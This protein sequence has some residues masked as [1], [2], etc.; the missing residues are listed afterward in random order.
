[1]AKKS[2]KAL[3]TVV[4]AKEIAAAAMLPLWLGN[5]MNAVK[6]NRLSSNEDLLFEQ[7]A[8]IMITGD[9]TFY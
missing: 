8:Y 3:A 1:M 5:V 9:Q 2:G 6:L 7:I 4:G